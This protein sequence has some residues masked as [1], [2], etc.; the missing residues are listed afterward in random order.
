MLPALKTFTKNLK[1]VNQNKSCV[2]DD[3]III[4]FV[5]INAPATAYKS[6]RFDTQT[7]HTGLRP[8]LSLNWPKVT[9]PII[10]PI[11][12]IEMLFLTIFVASQ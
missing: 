8:K 3:K 5:I 9:A 10:N 11:I 2:N 1:T 6:F 4:K 12:W 7:F